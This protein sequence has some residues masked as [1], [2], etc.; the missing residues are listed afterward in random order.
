VHGTARFA[1]AAIAVLLGAMLFGVV[2]LCSGASAQAASI[3]L[4]GGTEA[5]SIPLTVHAA[6]AANG[7]HNPVLA[8]TL[9]LTL[10]NS[11]KQQQSV[12]ILLAGD[13]LPGPTTLGRVTLGPGAVRQVAASVT[14][15]AGREPDAL[16]GTVL[17]E[18][19]AS[20]Q[21]RAIP[22]LS[23]PV[24]ATIAPIGDVRFAPN[25][26]V[27]QVTRWCLAL[28]PCNTTR[29]G[30]VELSGSG[31]PSLLAALAAA[32]NPP[33]ATK[34]R[35][36]V[37]TL[38][39][40]L[41]DLQAD[42][43]HAG[44]AT[45]KLLLGA[46]PPAGTF[47]GT[48]ALSALLP[49]APSLSVQVHSRYMFLW[50]VL[51][52]FL[53][54]L[55][56]G[57]LYQQLGLSRRKRLLREMMANAINGEYCPRHSENEIDGPR[58]PATL[59]WE[60]EIDCPLIDNRDWTYYTDLNTPANI[61]TAV[62]WARNDADL[63][64]AQ[65]AAVTVV[66]A[67]KTWL[68]AITDVRGLWELAEEARP[69]QERWDS[70]KTA[71]DSRL[72]LSKARRT[73]PDPASCA[74][75]LAKVKQQTSWH[76]AL[77]EAWD[78]RA[79]L[80]QLGGDIGEAAMEVDLAQLAAE[81]KPILTRDDDEQDELEL[82][83][84]EM[85]GKLITLVAQSNADP[86]THEVTVAPPLESEREAVS[87]RLRGE[88]A[89]LTGPTDLT[90]ALM[91][92]GRAIIP[93]DGEAEPPAAAAAAAA[94][95]GG[96]KAPADSPPARDRRQPTRD[97]RPP[98]PPTTNVRYG[99]ARRLRLLDLFMSAA[100]LLAIS[101]LYAV[102]IYGPAWGSI[103]DW[104]SAFGAGF[105]G[106]VTVKWALLPIYRSLRLRAPAAAGGT[107][108]AGGAEA[109]QAAAAA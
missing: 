58:G 74:A 66:R 27:V 55:A 23:L 18:A 20:G 109:A 68:L 25:P 16:D 50:A 90:F 8:G 1:T 93:T 100:I 104:A 63:D 10:R 5:R 60:P 102:T 15:P 36:G 44:T 46:K 85:R 82:K 78:V 22:Q 91:Q 30:T 43:D 48:I 39:V 72:L 94:A 37:N 56:A 52:I 35:S 69:Q 31:V 81:A 34:L 29:G 19:Q 32:G 98:A 6:S 87:E 28:F 62:Y 21:P 4:I 83:L 79:K 77:A 70:T 12:S 38:D 17:V 42:P 26:S 99:L 76:R 89:S 53:G 67:V 71:W 108:A 45:A 41:T 95:A 57:Y 2:L 101:L 61:Y 80:I 65:A 92:A 47:T 97:R 14:L 24:T 13:V 73:P 106:Q 9:E 7:A 11:A 33:L 54:V 103:A 86:S 75:L 64:E 88:I 107:S 84:E 105:G 96:G 3:E 51:C 59:I 49:Q 40:E